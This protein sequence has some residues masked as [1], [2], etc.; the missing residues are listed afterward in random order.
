MGELL[1]A[2]SAGSAHLCFRLV[3]HFHPNYIRINNHW[4]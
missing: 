1:P 2:Y 4:R 3:F